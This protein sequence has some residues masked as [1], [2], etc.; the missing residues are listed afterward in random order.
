MRSEVFYGSLRTAVVPTIPNA[1]SIVHQVETLQNFAD[2]CNG[3]GGHYATQDLDEE[4]FAPRFHPEYRTALFT[5]LS[6]Y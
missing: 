2:K 6:V 5:H 3:F 4:A 1:R